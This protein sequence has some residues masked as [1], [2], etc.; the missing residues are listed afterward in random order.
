MTAATA[1]VDN[2]YVERSPI[3]LRFRS[4]AHCNARTDEAHPEPGVERNELPI[5]I[6]FPKDG[7]EE[8]E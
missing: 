3:K 8:G 7:E 4:D 5:D 2:E 6:P 1:Q